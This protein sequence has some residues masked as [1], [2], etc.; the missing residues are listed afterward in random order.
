MTLRMRILAL[1]TGLT[2]VVLILFAV[3]LAIALGQ[4][5]TDRAI[6]ESEFVTQG[7]ADYLSTGNFTQRQSEAF[8]KRVNERNGTQVAVLLPGGIAIG[9]SLPADTP[10]PRSGE[11]YQSE[12]DSDHDDL[13]AVTQPRTTK[14]HDGWLIDV[15]ATSKTGRALV[16]GYV[17]ENVI[18]REVQGGWAWV[19]G[20]A[21]ALLILSVAGAEL[22][23][24][25]L[26]R[27]LVA[28]A[29]TARA[30]SSGDLDAR[31]PLGGAREI[32]QLSTA[33]NQLADRI[34]DLLASERETIA[35]LSHRLRTPMTAI[36]LDV[37]ALPDS[38][39]SR[40]LARHVAQ[41]ERTL[42]TVISNARLPQK[43]ATLRRCDASQVIRDRVAFWTPLAEDQGR[44]V[45]VS[46]PDAVI[47]VSCSSD[48]L[49]ASV[50]ALLEN[51]V[52]HTPE[53]SALHVELADGPDH[54]VLEII[55]HGAGIP[56]GSS[57]R[58]RSDRGST[59]LGLDIARSCA[60]SSGGSLD[61]RRGTDGT[62]IV[63]LSLQHS[64]SRI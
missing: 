50:D 59:G 28:T 23:S 60:E 30:L 13:G 1:S 61:I 8:V 4:A 62:N 29:S 2:A 34:E 9:A 11:T 44:S 19:G 64:H 25:R 7:V 63:R 21:A 55:D 35:D 32:S 10:V 18:R 33:L 3:P 52:A 12:G 46:V 39:K 54:A 22:V 41:L 45:T 58:G 6:Q 24:R 38:D 47:D 26:T 51:V 14:L 53:G 31:A 43:S 57:H 40:E 56:Q 5:A 27:P 36:R 37:E 42:T 20:G 49:A 15:Q 16:R 17:G 48:D